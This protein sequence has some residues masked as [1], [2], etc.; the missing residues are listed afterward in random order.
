MNFRILILLILTP[1]QL[2]NAQNGFQ[3][4]NN[5]KKVKI[6]FEIY[7]NLIVL[8]V[9]VNGEP[10][11]F[12]LDTG[13]K[14]SIIFSLDEFNEINFSKIE[15]IKIKGYGETNLYDAYKSTNNTIQINNLI[16]NNH[17]FYLILNQELNISTHLGIPINGIIGY[18][19]FKNNLI[20]INYLNKNIT[21]YN[22]NFKNSD[23]FKSKYS[24]LDVTFL[25]NKPFVTSNL[26]LENNDSIK[27]I[28]MLLDL[29]NSDAIWLLKNK[30]ITQNLPK[31][32]IK[33]YLG[34]GLSEDV[35]GDRARI[36][37][38]GFGQFNFNN[39]LVAFPEYNLNKN[40]DSIQERS[41]SIGSEIMRRFTIIL[42]YKSEAIYLKKNKNFDDPFSY[43]MS[44]LEIQHQGLQWI[45][46]TYQETATPIF[47]VYNEDGDTSFTANI[48]Y[49]FELKPIYI[50]LSV[51]ENSTAQIAGLQKNDVILK[52]NK[53]KAYNYKLQELLELFKSEDGKTIEIEVER[54]KKILLYK[55][56]LQKII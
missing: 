34:R 56:Q 31:T 10:L 8:S 33:D 22:E 53:K 17:T 18:H 27:K 41:G 38:I 9:K 21:V 49:K 50:I 3:I 54:N 13:V 40:T 39:P 47:N 16:D 32:T 26:E 7:N 51:R 4:E 14:E 2:C 52:V 36:K 46:Q 28:T 55:F 12:L 1:L 45:K 15:T 5:S 35:Y 25:N 37:K 11:K 42:D 19:F 48:K 20:K 44:G 30:F 24:K 23:N 43:N 29:G 6:P